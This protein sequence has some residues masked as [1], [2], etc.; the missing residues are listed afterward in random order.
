MLYGWGLSRIGLQ[1]LNF[2][3]FD[4]RG[5]DE[6]L[7]SVTVILLESG[8]PPFK[9]NILPIWPLKMAEGSLTNLRRSGRLFGGLIEDVKRKAPQ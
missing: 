7:D 3:A 6:F 8:I 2:K 9:L 4:Q 1:M 5:I